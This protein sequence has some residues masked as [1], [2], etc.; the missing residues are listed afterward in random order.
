M[1]WRGADALRVTATKVVPY[2]AEH[3]NETVP[4]GVD[5]GMGLGMWEDDMS[6]EESPI[7]G[8]THTIAEPKRKP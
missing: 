5:V 1:T 3:I 6:R 2:N 4:R 8:R 7:T